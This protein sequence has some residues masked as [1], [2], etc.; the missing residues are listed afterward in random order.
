MMQGV[1]NA[2]GEA[3]SQ[4]ALGKPDGVEVLVTAEERA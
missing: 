2:N 4:Q 1:G 3:E